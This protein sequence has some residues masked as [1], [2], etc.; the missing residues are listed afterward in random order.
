[1]SSVIPPVTDHDNRFLW[2][3]VAAGK[4]MLQRC[5]GCEHIRHPPRPMCPEC[6]STDWS[7]Q[8]SSGR[9]TIYSWIVSRPPYEP[10]AEPRIVV[11]VDLEE[12]VRFVANL[13]GL[14]STEVRNGMPVEVFFTE[15]GG[16]VLPQFRVSQPS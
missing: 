4:L 13:Q 3:G 14:P 15:V 8:E 9:G 12:G 2:E 6:L 7:P 10:N 1:M 5:S 16:V 11:L